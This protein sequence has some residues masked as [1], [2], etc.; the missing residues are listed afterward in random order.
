M[1]F[2]NNDSYKM[3]SSTVNVSHVGSHPGLHSHEEQQQKS[4][5]VKKTIQV[6]G[7]TLLSRLLGLA[8]EI[9]MVN[10]LGAGIVSDAFFT[11]YKIPN[12]LRKVFAEGAL[13]AAFVPTFVAVA[14]KDARDVNS[15]MT[16]SFLI[17][18]GI[19]I[20]LCALIFFCADWV[21]KL[22][23][24]GW[25]S[26]SV[27][28][29]SDSY[30][31]Q[32]IKSFAPAWYS[33]I[34]APQAELAVMYLRI[35]ISFIV[36]LSSSALLAGALQAVNHFFIPALCSALLNVVFIGGIA[37][38][39][40]KGLSVNALCY[41]II[42][43][44]L[45]QF[46]LHLGTY[47]RFNFSFAG[48]TERSWGY[49]KQIVFKFIP[50]LFSMSINEINL[51]VSTSLASYLPSGSITLIY[52]ANR[53]MGIPLGVFSTAFSTI[54]LPYFSRINIDAP[55]RLGFYLY[56]SAKVIF[57]V[58]I[59]SMV[60]M[61][62]LSEKIFHTMFLSNKFSLEQVTQAH[63]ILITFLCGLFF[64]SLNK[65]ML[66][67][68]YSRQDTVTPTIVSLL[69]AFVNYC[70][71]SLLLPIFGASGL[72]LAIVIAS[73]VQ[74]VLFAVFLYRIPSFTF[75]IKE[76]FQFVMQA[77]MQIGIIF[78]FF[79]VIYNTMMYG[80]SRSCAEHVANFLLF[81]IGFWLWAGPLCLVMVGV[82]I[83]T[84]K[85]FKIDLYFLD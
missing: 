46:L 13:S 82:L 77:V 18:E 55:H 14:K 73:V 80:I 43:G 72:A 56:E 29:P 26:G 69:S 37:I 76:F 83:K 16:L 53:F 54:L 47:F 19:L 44:G 58:T 70:A 12:S 81:K 33:T 24:P 48:I 75:H 79:V 40:W 6:G 34:A 41:F 20:S 2:E 63:Y 7:S 45:L 1:K 36:F 39:M 74:S 17:F 60:V 59:S 49:F 67:I 61:I 42:F 30:I 64:F 11:A 50:C 27:V 66:N 68:Y 5:I 22:I 9:L 38:C 78:T 65:I 10:F 31:T 28:L 62:F 84:R 32:C 52:Y 4:T 23:A 21:I 15:L 3:A 57:W 71:S 35:L 25:F 51:F 8:R 85:L